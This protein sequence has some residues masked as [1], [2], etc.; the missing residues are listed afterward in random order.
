MTDAL[1]RLCKS[2]DVFLMPL[3]DAT[4]ALV[5]EEGRVTTARRMQRRARTE[6]V[7]RGGQATNRLE[8]EQGGRRGAAR[9]LHRIAS[10]PPYP[11]WASTLGF[12][13]LRSPHLRETLALSR[14]LAISSNKTFTATF[15]SCEHRQRLRYAFRGTDSPRSGLLV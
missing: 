3:P 4:K 7:L 11:H 13:R 14:N 10:H 5:L 8:S 15:A 12:Y 1:G 2:A 6:L 9:A